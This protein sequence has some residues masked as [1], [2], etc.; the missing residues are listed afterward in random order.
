MKK[1]IGYKSKGY[2]VLKI[3]ILIPII[4]I[5]IGSIRNFLHPFAIIYMLFIAILG[6]YM[7]FRFFEHLNHPINILSYDV[8][9]FY[10]DDGHHEEKI[11]IL[12]IEHV[13]AKN[14]V[15]RYAL[16]PFG[17]VEI[18]TKD[19]IF[20]TGYVSDVAY[21]AKKISTIVNHHKDMKHQF[22][23]DQLSN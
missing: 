2:G 9:Y 23:I 1:T 6:V 11:S 12:N 8:S 5:I 18:H 15:S 21:V 14:Y 16:F 19:G 4:V 22:L 20:Y 7:L 10:I 17:R 13:Q 3:I